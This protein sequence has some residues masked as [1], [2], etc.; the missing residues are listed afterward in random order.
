MAKW[1]DEVNRKIGVTIRAQ[2]LREKKEME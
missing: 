1:P 2:I